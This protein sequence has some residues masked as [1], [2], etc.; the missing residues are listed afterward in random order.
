MDRHVVFGLTGGIASGKST[1]AKTFAAAG[2][3]IVDADQL[4]RHIFD[5]GKPA[6]KQLVKA[7]GDQILLPDGSMNRKLVG[8]MVFGDAAKRE[9]IDRIFEPWIRVESDLAF[10]KHRPMGNEPSLVCYD[11]PLLVEKG[12]ALDFR[13]VVVVV[14]EPETQLARLM[15]RNGLTEV[16]AKQRIGAQATVEERLKVADFVIRTDGTV[17]ESRTQALEVLSK[18]KRY[19]NDTPETCMTCRSRMAWTFEH[20]TAHC[21]NPSCNP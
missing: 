2:V 6:L 17:E 15:K 13:P 11:A 16:E 14:C 8:E 18:I 20:P 3:P 21:R 19:P 5:V 7:F 10:L 9:I 1:V 4:S 12:F